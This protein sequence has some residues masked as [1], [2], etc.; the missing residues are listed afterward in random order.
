MEAIRKILESGN[1]VTVTFTKRDGSTR[2]LNGRSGVKKG[3]N[4]QGLPYDKKAK[5]IVVLYDCDIAK[6][7]KLT[8]D[9]PDYARK[10][11]RA[12]RLDSIRTIKANGLTYDL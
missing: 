7:L 4:G 3:V 9:N 6:R 10:C 5:D 11:Y 8:P 1:I 12:V 2:V